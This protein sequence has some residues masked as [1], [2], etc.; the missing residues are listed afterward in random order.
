MK[1]EGL[2]TGFPDWHFSQDEEIDVLI[3]KW[4]AD[5]LNNTLPEEGD[6]WLTEEPL[7]VKFYLSLGDKAAASW[8]E[9]LA[10]IVL[11]HVE[12]ILP[13]GKGAKFPLDNECKASAAKIAQ[14]LRS[15]ADQVD[16]FVAAEER[17]RG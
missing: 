7:G 6:L 14:D 2:I 17:T 13:G 5:A 10:D 16:A 3:S 8:T 1:Y 15:I 9:P 11:G 4:V 12:G